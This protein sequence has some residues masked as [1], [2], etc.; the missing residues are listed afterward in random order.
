MTI[1]P[2]CPTTGSQSVD[3]H[4]GLATCANINNVKP[5]NRWL[6][7]MSSSYKTN[8]RRQRLDASCPFNSV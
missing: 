6:L 5:Q 2:E 8:P 3:V 1:V 7:C 4:P